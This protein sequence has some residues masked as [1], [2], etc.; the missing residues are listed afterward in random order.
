MTTQG[1]RRNY[2][3]PPREPPDRAIGRSR[4][5]LTT[6]IHLACDGQG[7]PLSLWL[8]GGNVNDSTELA[9]VMA[10]IYVARLGPGRPRTR[11]DRL[12]GDK[13][14]SSRGN[15]ALLADRGIKVTIPEKD[16]QLGHRR[17]RGSAGGRPYAFDPSIYKNRNV[18]ERGF[19]RFKHWRG[20][21][22]RF[23]KTAVC[24]L[25]GLTL[26]SLLLWAGS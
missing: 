7:R 24:Y 14:Y 13:G 8:T 9:A 17:R 15:R 16:D 25:G 10:G 20:L 22:S 2:K 12:I 21:A 4:G 26:A 18:V 5:G 23:D 11:P 19:N 6:K 1:A 3:F